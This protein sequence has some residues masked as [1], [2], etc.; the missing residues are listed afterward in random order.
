MK[1][2]TGD[3]KQKDLIV[4]MLTALFPGVKIYLFGSRAKGTHKFESDI[5]LALDAGR[6]LDIGEVVK[7]KNVLEAVNI[8]R[9]VDVIDLNRVSGELRDSILKEGLLWT[10]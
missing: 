2:N 10:E 4:R 1:N 5:D 6:T 8:L 7:A 3:V 9:N